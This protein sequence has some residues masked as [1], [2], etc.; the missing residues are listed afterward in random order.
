MMM[1]QYIKDK[2]QI[3]DISELLEENTA[4]YSEVETTFLSERSEYDQTLH[5]LNCKMLAR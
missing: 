2:M 1:L 4:I 3:Q 5:D